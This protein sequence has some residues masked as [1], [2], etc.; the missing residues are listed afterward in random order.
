MEMFSFSE[1]INQR[2]T[3]GNWGIL[4]FRQSKQFG[5]VFDAKESQ[6][7]ESK[8]LSKSNSNKQC[9]KSATETKLLE[10]SINQKVD[11]H[12]IHT[13]VQ[14]ITSKNSQFL[15]KNTDQKDD[16]LLPELNS[17]VRN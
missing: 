11:N 9:S 2:I 10:E 14:S 1:V 4:I 3:K 16:I 7:S 13:R 12:L 15:L 5:D 8:N 6:K 17:Q